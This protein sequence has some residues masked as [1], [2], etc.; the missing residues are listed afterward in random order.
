[1]ISITRKAKY[2]RTLRKDIVVFQLD[3]IAVGPGFV[4]VQRHLV[5]LKRNHGGGHPHYPRTMA[6]F[7][8]NSPRVAAGVGSI[9]PGP[10]VHQ[11]P[12]EKL[13]P[14]IVAVRVVVQ[15]VGQAEFSK[16][17]DNPLRILLSREFIQIRINP[18]LGSAQPNDLAQK[19]PCQEDL[20]SGVVDPVDLSIGKTSNPQGVTETAARGDLGTPIERG[21]LP[22]SDSEIEGAGER[23]LP[24]G[25]GREAV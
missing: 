13:R 14:G 4:W 21:A 19:R 12:I 6:V 11:C 17:Q 23:G 1:M 18:F 16:S 10:I 8:G 9:V 22:E 24:L 15:Q 2:P 3:I 7:H 25:M 20:W 5:G